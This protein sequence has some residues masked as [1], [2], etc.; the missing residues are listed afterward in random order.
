MS[1]EQSNKPVKSNKHEAV[2]ALNEI[3]ERYPRIKT[4][5][6]ERFAPVYYPVAMVEMLLEEQTFEDFET[7]HLAVLRL[8]SLG[9]SDYKLIAQTLGLSASYVFKVLHL[10]T[11][12]G[13]IADGRLTDLG[14]ESLQQ[15]KK[16]ITTDTLQKFQVDALNGRLLKNHQV[17]AGNMLNSKDETITMIGHLNYLDGM[18]SQNLSSQLT[19]G[20][21][22]NYL[23]QKSGVLHTN[24]RRIKAARCTEI[25]YAKCYLLKLRGCT[26]PFIFA[27]RYN[28]MG[29]EQKLRFPWQPFSAQDAATA[30]RYGLEPDT[31]ANTQLTTEYVQQL[32]QMLKTQSSGP[33]FNLEEQVTKTI[34]HSTPFQTELLDVRPG[35]DYTTGIERTTVYVPEKAVVKFS[36]ELVNILAGISRDD[37]YLITDQ[38][39][40][41]HV[42]SVRIRDGKLR[43]LARLIADKIAE[44]GQ[45]KVS[46]VLKDRFRDQDNDPKLTEKMIACLQEIRSTDG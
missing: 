15:Q 12:Y 8:I 23:N 34:S 11:G 3:R 7:V 35:M 40:Y 6:I 18:D 2:Y 22:E 5:D 38:W 27:K 29:E 45:K 10:L 24:V 37:E 9:I 36:G 19:G 25:K 20:N 13:H 43:V 21:C 14:R 26:Q 28:R 1:K 42:V 33:K 32:Y 17:V 44:H 31:P 30:R 39:L 4:T 41:G 46:R 16:I